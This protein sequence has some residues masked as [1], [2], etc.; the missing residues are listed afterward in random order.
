MKT[1]NFN[2]YLKKVN[3]ELNEKVNGNKVNENRNHN[4]MRVIPRDFF[5]ESKLLKCMGFLELAILDRKLPE[6]INIEIEDSGDPFE[7]YLDEIWGILSVS[8]YPVTVNGET[9]QFGTTYNSKSNF[10]FVV[11]KDDIDI[12]VFDEN[13]KF[14]QD[15]IESFK[16]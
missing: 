9:Y 2:Y 8:N 12:E 3:G 7:I 6:G 4:Y 11:I 5:N 16:E 14:T 13:G 15:F 10:P 1:K